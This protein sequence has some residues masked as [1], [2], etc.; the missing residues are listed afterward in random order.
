MKPNHID[1]GLAISG[2][3]S[4][5]GTPKTQAEIANWCIYD[6]TKHQWRTLSRQRVDQIER[7]ALRKIRRYLHCHPDVRDELAALFGL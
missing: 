4:T 1:L 5:F 2:C 6:P 7:K 3:H